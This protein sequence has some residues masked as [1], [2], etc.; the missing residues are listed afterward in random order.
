M[1]LQVENT[2][3]SEYLRNSVASAGDLDPDFNGGGIVSFKFTEDGQVL[4][5]VVFDVVVGA[6]K[7]IYISGT[8]L[9]EYTIT[10][11]EEDGSIVRSFGREGTV[12]ASFSGQ[13][14][15]SEGGVISIT[16]NRVFI[17][18]VF[19]VDMAGGSRL[20]P[21][22]AC[23]DLNGDLDSAYGINGYCI[24]NPVFSDAH[25]EFLVRGIRPNW[26]RF[27]NKVYVAGFRVVRGQFTEMVVSCVDASGQIDTEF[28]VAGTAIVQHARGPQ[29]ESITAT[30]DGIYL[31]GGFSTNA[32]GFST[33][34]RLTYAGELDR[35]FGVEGFVTFETPFSF[36]Y[37][38]AVQKEQKLLG[39]G[40]HV[41]DEQEGDV[42]IR[43]QGALVG[44]ERDGRF[45]AEFNGGEPL[46]SSLNYVTAWTHGAVLQDGKIVAFGVHNDPRE[47]V[48]T[49]ATEDMYISHQPETLASGRLVVA[50][51]LRDGSFDT[52]FGR[53]KQ[54]W[55]TFNLGVRD[56]V[57]GM[58]V[59]PDNK[60]VLV[61]N[62]V[63]D[64]GYVV[65]RFKG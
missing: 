64:S 20:C 48:S 39:V 62:T 43:Y 58:T 50:R 19:R 15:R 27:G 31:A 16:E 23:H 38:L 57:Y 63:E 26:V 34:C 8:T 54:G 61:G 41:A 56:V 33:F 22:I 25:P 28:G 30:Q 65:I 1:K 5:G 7:R 21:A 55:V 35:S 59:Q 42:F 46:Y 32:V 24:V 13:P 29:F 44:F 18:G 37:D 6:D 40:R 14:D 45:D 51:F 17:L 49:G 52:A 60:I 3:M 36:V 2:S 12:F 9:D 11:L 4:D 47:K 53:E 10:A